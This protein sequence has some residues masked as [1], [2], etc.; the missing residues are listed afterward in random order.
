[1]SL[2]LMESDSKITLWGEGQSACSETKWSPVGPADMY[3]SG[4]VAEHSS[5]WVS[6]PFSANAGNVNCLLWETCMLCPIWSAQAVSCIRVSSS[7]HLELS[8]LLNSPPLSLPFQ[9]NSRSKLLKRDLSWVL[10]SDA[11]HFFD[12][13]QS[14]SF[15]KVGGFYISIASC[16][17]KNL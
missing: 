9:F 13:Y 16:W 14:F 4:Q 2:F 17:K 10:L 11:G 8:S 12:V 3:N 7:F 6:F 1:M 5:A 15:C